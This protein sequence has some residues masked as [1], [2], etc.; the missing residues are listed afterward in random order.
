[1]RVPSGKTMMEIPFFRIEEALFK[2][3]RADWALCRSIKTCPARFKNQP[4][5][6]NQRR[7]FLAMNRTGKGK[8]EIIAGISRRLE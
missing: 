6:G 2:L 7:D 3:F 1:M 4:K 5:I 8:A